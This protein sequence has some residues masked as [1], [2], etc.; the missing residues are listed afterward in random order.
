MKTS[1]AIFHGTFEGEDVTVMFTRE[2]SS[3][4]VL[5]QKQYKEIIL[6][7]SQIDSQTRP[8]VTHAAN[9][10]QKHFGRKRP[11]KTKVRPKSKKSKHGLKIFS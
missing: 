1:V 4:G 10:V 8:C 9:F 7:P 5:L 11:K 3:W 2:S 6:R